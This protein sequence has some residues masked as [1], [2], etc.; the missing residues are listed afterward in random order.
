[1]TVDTDEKPPVLDEALLRTRYPRFLEVVDNLATALSM[2]ATVAPAA[3]TLLSTAVFHPTLQVRQLSWLVQMVNEVYDGRQAFEA[4]D[5][6][7]GRK[8]KVSSYLRCMA[9]LW[10][11]WR[12]A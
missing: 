12:V 4:V 10:R 9:C 6:G 1:M 2:N 8:G 7:A 11:W 5:K 3:G